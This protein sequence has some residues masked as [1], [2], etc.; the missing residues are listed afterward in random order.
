MLG[1]ECMILRIEDMKKLMEYL[2]PKMYTEDYTK[3]AEAG[4]LKIYDEII[5]NIREWE[6]KEEA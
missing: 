1:S 4:V 5:D 6:R 2:T 3:M